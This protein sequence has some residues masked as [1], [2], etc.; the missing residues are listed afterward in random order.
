MLRCYE[1]K[2][3]L[4]KLVIVGVVDERGLRVWVISDCCEMRVSVRNNGPSNKEDRR[5]APSLLLYVCTVNHNG[6]EPCSRYMLWRHQ[7]AQLVALPVAAHM[8]S[9]LDT[10][11]L[12]LV[13]DLLL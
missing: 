5:Y 11:A 8:L 2:R 6:L 4:G 9:C 7:D 3:A 10:A 1:K 13:A 12:T